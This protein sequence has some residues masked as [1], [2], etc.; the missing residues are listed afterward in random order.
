MALALPGLY[1]HQNATS[2]NLI[3]G[4]SG[5]VISTTVVGSVIG[6]GGQSG[7]PNRVWANYATVSG[8]YANTASAFAAV[9]GGGETNNASNGYATIGGGALNVSS[10]NYAAICGGRG[11]I[12]SGASATIGGGWGNIASGA[13]AFVGG[14]G[15]DG[16]T[17]DSNQAVGDASTI[18]G[19]LGNS[20]PVTGTYATIGGGKNNAADNRYATV[21]GG[22]GNTAYGSYTTV[23]GG[24]LN[25]AT[26]SYSTIGGGIY[27][28]TS[29][30][31]ATVPGGAGASASHYGE[32][33]YASGY[34]SSL[35]DAQTSLYVVHNTTTNATQTELFLDGIAKR[36]TIANIWLNGRT[37]TFDILVVAR[38]DSGLSAGYR[39]AGVIRYNN[40]TTAFIGTPTITTLGENSAGWDV[41]VGADDSYEALV[42]KVMGA[43]ATMIRWVA[44]VR[45]VEVAW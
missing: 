14:G 40:G 30:T 17:V 18:S 44:S 37:V 12:A 25:M 43:T 13:G 45:T 22:D 21:G 31:Y 41:T 28:W 5:N 4:Y 6:G 11:N 27:N 26:S 15:K 38:S 7:L 19:G 2:P 36:I 32:M 42:V 39:I 16:A 23:G 24:L 8:G 3:G 34:F 1:T 20:I 35:G 29:D 9:V 33:A 10:G